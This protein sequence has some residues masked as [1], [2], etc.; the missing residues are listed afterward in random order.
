MWIGFKL[1]W[2]AVE[3]VIMNLALSL[4]CCNYVI[5]RGLVNH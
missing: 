4:K 1:F 2:Q 5:I 3:N